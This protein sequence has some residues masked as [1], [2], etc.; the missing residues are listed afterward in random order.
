M[1]RAY[2]RKVIDAWLKDDVRI[3]IKVSIDEQQI[4]KLIDRLIVT[5]EEYEELAKRTPQS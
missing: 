2:Y 1:N 4:E 3:N 5:K